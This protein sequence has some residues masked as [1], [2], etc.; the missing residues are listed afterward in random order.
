MEQPD[1]DGHGE[2]T[3][4]SAYDR[5][6]GRGNIESSDEEEAEAEAEKGAAGASRDVEQQAPKEEGEEASVEYGEETSRLALVNVD[7]D[8]LTAADIFKLF[9]AF[10]PA[11]GKIENVSIYTS[12]FG[13]KQIAEEK[14]NGPPRDIFP[15]GFSEKGSSLLPSESASDPNTPDQQFN[16]ENLRKYQLSRLRY[17]Y[18][19]VTCSSTSTARTIY[20]Q[21]DGLELESSA[22]VI[23]L[24]YIP[25]G[26]EFDAADIAAQCSRGQV[27]DYKPAQD[28]FTPALQHTRVDL[29]WEQEDVKRAQVL[30]RKRGK[31]DILMDD[32]KDYLASEGSDDESDVEE[33][34]KGL[35]EDAINGHAQED[36]AD[37]GM[38]IT[39][40]SALDASRP[41]SPPPSSSA[42]NNPAK[43]KG[44]SSLGVA[45]AVEGDFVEGDAE[46][47]DDDFFCA[48]ETTGK[49]SARKIEAEK[50]A[51]E[52]ELLE[53]SGDEKA[54]L[55]LLMTDD[56]TLAADGRIVKSA[57]DESRHF[58][59]RE[60]MKKE[61]QQKSKKRK[62]KNAQSQEEQMMIQP[63]FKMDLTD[64]RFA[65]GLEESHEFF[66]DPTN[67]KF[68]KTTEMEKL[69]SAVSKARGSKK[70]R[71]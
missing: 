59:A 10:C 31:K 48:P 65:R 15:A 34:Y 56:I 67:P 23:D 4:I 20:T 8:H 61:K 71:T 41:I 2:D 52:V 5:A 17:Y 70:P 63:G 11:D 3:E 38:A 55:D 40:G 12:E 29:S 62:R 22:N 35:L 46:A 19:V 51:P 53:S 27:E 9:E 39:F 32:F 25:D 30:R 54:E 13:K 36:E 18:A 42:L 60:I 24:R 64:E 6:R 28:F 58:D 50:P 57:M 66:I 45:P 69:R 26:T 14:L 16:Q 37:D 68:T 33:K 43:K 44:S 7:W 47:F 1:E 49:K 21:C